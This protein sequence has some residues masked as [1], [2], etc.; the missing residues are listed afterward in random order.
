MTPRFVPLDPRVHYQYI[1]RLHIYLKVNVSSLKST[2]LQLYLILHP[3]VYVISLVHITII[4][5]C[6]SHTTS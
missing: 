5:A 2:C 6:I 3:H 1:Q 4:F